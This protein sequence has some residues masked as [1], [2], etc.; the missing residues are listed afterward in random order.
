MS[1]RHVT[2][3]LTTVFSVNL[4]S[5][6]CLTSK[7]GRLFCKAVLTFYYLH[8]RWWIESKISPIALYFYYLFDVYCYGMPNRKVQRKIFNALF[9]V[10]NNL[11]EFKAIAGAWKVQVVNVTGV[12]VNLFA[13]RR[14]ER[15]TARC[16]SS[17]TLPCRRHLVIK[18]WDVYGDGN[19]Y[20]VFWVITP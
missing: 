15:Q 13:V 5:S 19:L 3:Y 16:T 14:I 1:L 4:H 11:A 7:S 2:L 10:V 9:R 6:D 20:F 8:T 12:A 17:V 18:F